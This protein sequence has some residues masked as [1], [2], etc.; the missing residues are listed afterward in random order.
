MSKDGVKDITW[1]GP[2]SREKT[3][4]QWQD[5]AQ[6]VLGL[7]LNSEP[8]ELESGNG[9]TIPGEIILLI[10]NAQADPITFVLPTLPRSGVWVSLLDTAVT[11]GPAPPPV[12]GGEGR[13]IEGRS[14]V[15]C[16]FENSHPQPNSGS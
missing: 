14:V 6:R 3:I 11:E 4:E 16:Q 1:L 9:G 7:M 5:P 2:D 8:R 15:V 10:F 12:P 13:R